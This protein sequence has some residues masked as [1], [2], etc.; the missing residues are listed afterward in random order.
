MK[1]IKQK[2]FIIINRLKFFFEDKDVANFFWV[3]VNS[4]KDLSY[5]ISSVSNQNWNK[6]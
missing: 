2:I 6:Y 4:C 3:D 5:D 1:K